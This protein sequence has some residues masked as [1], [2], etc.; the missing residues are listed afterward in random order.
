MFAGGQLR[1]WS[2]CLPHSWITGLSHCT[3]PGFKQLSKGHPP[4]ERPYEIATAHPQCG[5]MC[6]FNSWSSE[7]ITLV[8]IL[9][10]LAQGYTSLCEDCWVTLHKPG[11]YSLHAMMPH[12]AQVQPSAPGAWRTRQHE[13]KSSPKQNDATEVNTG[14]MGLPVSRTQQDEWGCQW[15]EHGSH[16]P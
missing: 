14:W 12:G 9:H 10:R 5:I 15:A 6:C 11:W 7:I 1:P 13:K 3:H 4:Q 8:T 2:F 16:S